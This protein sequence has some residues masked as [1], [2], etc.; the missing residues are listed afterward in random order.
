MSFSDLLKKVTGVF[1]GRAEENEYKI[2]ATSAAL[3]DSVERLK[4]EN[5]DAISI[6]T[7]HAAN[8]DLYKIINEYSG[9]MDTY[10]DINKWG[11]SANIKIILKHATDN[12]E[13]EEVMGFVDYI[14]QNPTII[15]SLDIDDTYNN[16]VMEALIN[17]TNQCP[18]ELKAQIY[19][20]LDASD[21]LS[22]AYKGSNISN[23]AFFNIRA[24]SDVD[25]N[26]AL[27]LLRDSDSW[28]DIPKTE[29]LNNLLE[30]NAKHGGEKLLPAMEYSDEEQPH[31]IHDIG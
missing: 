20:K 15:R 10:V 3:Q 30:S 26:Q 1:N 24:L 23:I 21:F 19:S 27:S 28:K 16:H 29:L 6:L 8:P 2:K 18:T 31:T 5:C 13:P 25:D 4:T 17:I 14:T 12:L 9:L 7:E 22:K 11:H